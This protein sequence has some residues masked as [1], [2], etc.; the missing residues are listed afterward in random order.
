MSAAVE[1]KDLEVLDFTRRHTEA[2]LCAAARSDFRAFV[3]YVMRNEETGR[4]IDLAPLHYRWFQ[5]TENYDRLVL[6][7]FVESGKTLSLSVARTLYKLGRDPTLR[8]AI[9]SNTSTMATKIANLIGRYIESSEALH[10]VFPDLV[11]DPSMPWN[12]EQLTVQRSTMSKDPSVNTLGV[13]SNTQ[14][15]RIDEAILDDILNRENTRTEYMR[16]GVLDWY[17]KTI[18]GRMTARGRILAIGNAFH[19]QDLLHT[20]ARNPRWHAFKYPILSKDGQSAWPEVWSL[21]RIEKRRQEI[22]PIEF[23]SQL[24]CQ[25]T[26][27]STSRFKREWLDACKARG[28]GKSMVYALRAVPTGCKVYCGVDLGVGLKANNDMTVFFVIFVHPNGDR[29]VLWVESGR[30]VATDIMAKV[31]DLYERFHCVFVIENVAAQQF[32]VQ[33]LQNNTSIPIVPFTTGKNKADAS[34]GV[35][36]MGIEMACRPPKWIIPSQGGRSHPEIEEWVGEMLSYHPDAHAGDRLM[37]SWFA[38]EGE[39]LG[40]VEPKPEVG[41]VYLNL[42]NW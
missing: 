12:S 7:A 13:G 36:A 24:M 5:I 6:W 38:K 23:Q 42:S 28:E 15:A 37:S 34:F 19:P 10:E 2:K 18:P 25:A 35:E 31:V 26:D 27:D 16:A 9:V 32:L 3:Q 4:T 39:R 21:A 17:L 8:F 20:M 14:G 29:E 40:R 11:P 1:R 22:G 33:I 41:S 30:W